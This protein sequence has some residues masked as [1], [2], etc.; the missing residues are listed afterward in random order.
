M[1]DPTGE[2]LQGKVLYSH[3]YKVFQLLAAAL[4]AKRFQLRQLHVLYTRICCKVHGVYHG[5][6]NTHTPDIMAHFGIVYDT[7][8][9]VCI[10]N[11]EPHVQGALDQVS[12]CSFEC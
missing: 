9:L 4:E 11:E 12:S 8:H 10:D 6:C 2:K 1:S 3:M 7:F 5:Q